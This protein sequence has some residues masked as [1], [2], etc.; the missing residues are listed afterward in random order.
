VRELDDVSLGVDS[1][2]RRVVYNRV[3]QTRRGRGITRRQLAAALGVHYQTLGYIERHEASPSLP[4]A[5][6][7][8]DLLGSPV[9]LIF[10]TKPFSVASDAGAAPASGASPVGLALTGDG[11]ILM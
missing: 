3:E 6:R 8:A 9:A 7:I 4:L 11:Q 10:S 5:L 1:S 2:A